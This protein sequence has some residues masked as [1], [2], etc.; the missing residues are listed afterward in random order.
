MN[1]W[2]HVEDPGA[3]NWMVSLVPE[4]DRRGHRTALV[5]DG[6]AVTYLAD[7]GITP[8]A[9]FAPEEANFVLTGTSENLRSRGLDEIGNARRRDIPSGAVVDQ[10]VNAAH[11]FSGGG[12][13]ALAF[14][15]DMIFVPDDAARDAFTALGLSPSRIAQVGNPHHDWLRRRRSELQG[16]DRT[17]LRQRLFPKADP[18]RAIVLFVSE[19]GYVVNPEAAQWTA[20]NRFHGR[21]GDTFRSAVV[22]E[23]LLD[24]CAILP[25]QPQVVLRL[26]PKNTEAEFAAYRGELAAMSASGDPLEAA[27]AAD[28]VIGMTSALLEDAWVIGARVMAVLPRPEEKFWLQPVGKDLIP[29]AGDRSELRRVLPEALTAQ[30]APPTAQPGTAAARIA[31]YIERGAP[32]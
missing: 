23:E 24:A 22:L 9:A 27:L 32:A 20:E 14:A 8:S 10:A 17:A 11:R 29:A 28:L 26:H 13:D 7:R 21:G 2:I 25:D 4:L 12:P 15:P 6:I 5:A 1:V 3:A 16:L 18:A 31:D 19:I 30:P